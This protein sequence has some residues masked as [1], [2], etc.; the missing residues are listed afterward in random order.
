VVGRRPACGLP[1]W[2]P[3]PGL[4]CVPFEAS[5]FVPHCT[6]ATADVYRLDPIDYGRRVAVEKELAAD[7][8][9]C[10]CACSPVCARSFARAS[11]DAPDLLLAGQRTLAAALRSVGNPGA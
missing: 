7:P 9:G 3:C 5:M 11:L 2:R 6:A 8:G 4:S 10:C 1:M